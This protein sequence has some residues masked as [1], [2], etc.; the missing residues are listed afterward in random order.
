MVELLEVK[1]VLY[2]TMSNLGDAIM[3]LPAF[4]FLRRCC[5]QAKIT[6]VAG[7]R[8]KC[9]FENHPDASELII[10]DKQASL[11]QK[12]DLFFKL[13]RGSFDVVVDLRDTFYRW[14]VKA[15]YKNPARLSYP[16]WVTH[17]SQKH[18]FN[19]YAHTLRLNTSMI[20]KI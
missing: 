14:G 2:I 17:A 19:G 10:F 18:L 16:S 1:K 6:V 20:H 9:I 7:P 13:K 12:I 8:T 15:C 4:D 11:R 3:A 5:P